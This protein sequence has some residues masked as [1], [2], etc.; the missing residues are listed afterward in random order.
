MAQAR[1]EKELGNAAYKKKEFETALNHYNE[2]VKLNPNDMTYYTNIAGKISVDICISTLHLQ[3]SDHVFI[4]MCL[5]IHVTAVY[6]EQKE[7]KKCIEQC[8]KAIEV[9]REN[10][11]DFKLIAKAFARI[12]N[13]YKKMEVSTFHV[14]RYLTNVENVRFCIGNEKFEFFQAI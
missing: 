13:A 4:S 2:A 12:G 6:F 11:A 7:F 10:R 3:S 5:V 8:E 14:F 1:N 9:G